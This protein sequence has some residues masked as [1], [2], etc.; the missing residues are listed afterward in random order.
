MTLPELVSFEAGACFGI[1]AL[2]AI[3]AVRLAGDLKN[4]TVLVIGGASAVGHYITQLVVLAGGK[5][6]TTIGSTAKAVHAQDAGAHHVVNYKTEPVAERIKQLTHGAGVD[7]IIDMDLSTTTHLL[8]QGCLKPHGLLVCYGSNVPGD[9]PIN[10]R[11]LLYASIGLKFFLVY[12][13]TEEA[14]AFGLQRF[15]ALLHANSLKH[16]IGATFPL[17]DLVKA[18]QMVE[19]GQVLGNVVV[20]I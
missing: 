12:D 1:P 18:H 8:T 5:V 2:T 9:V 14:R 11:T 20:Q 6:I 3:E 13:L 19:K 10:F 15:D 16:T 4:K 7:V 17:K